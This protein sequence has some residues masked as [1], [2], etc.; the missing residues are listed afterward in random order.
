MKKI[1]S[2]TVALAV[3]AIFISSAWAVITISKAEINQGA[4]AVNGKGA[5]ANANIFWE[6][7]VTKVTTANGKGAFNFTTTNLPVDC[8]GTL[9][10]GT[11]SGSPLKVVIANCGAHPLKT[12]QTDSFGAGSDGDLEKGTAR[13]YTP[14]AD[15]TITD[16]STGLVWE[17]LG[18]LDGSQNFTDLHDADNF[19]TWADAFAKI[20]ALNTANFAGHSDW[21]L[22][23]VN[24]LQSLADYGRVFPAIDPVFNNSVDSFTQSD[25]YWSSTKYQD[26][27]GRAWFV[28]F[29]DG[30]V[31]P[32]G[33][34]NG[35][36]VRAV[37]GGS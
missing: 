28:D 13:S 19:Y 17:K 11:I 36:Y 35:F 18:S 29:F 31:E 26:N 34:F 23:N 14:N 16:N 4:V 15:G 22:P 24:E 12:G 5:A 1:F 32:F 37:R 8:V 33:E 10:S 21:R 9:T 30:V 20:A 25:V 6:G 27:S 3:M 7:D 2:A